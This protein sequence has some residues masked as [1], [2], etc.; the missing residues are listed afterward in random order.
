[1]TVTP[2]Q[3]LALPLGQGTLHSYLVDLLN[4]L[5]AQG[6]DF[7]AKRPFGSSD[8]QW[9]VYRAMA[10]AG[11]VRGELDGDGE[12]VD[13]DTATADALIGAAI[14]SL[15]QPRVLHAGA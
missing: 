1:M 15:A 10:S 11:Y 6:S 7:N 4:T 14:T 5:W 3:V 13:V 8:W 9:T 2:E 12:L